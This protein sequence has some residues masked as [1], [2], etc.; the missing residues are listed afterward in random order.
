MCTTLKIFQT[1]ICWDS[2][3]RLLENFVDHALI[4]NEIGTQPWEI[5]I[6]HNFTKTT[7]IQMHLVQILLDW[8]TRPWFEI[9][10]LYWRK[11]MHSLVLIS[12]LSQFLGYPVSVSIRSSIDIQNGL[13]AHPT[14]S[15][16]WSPG[17]GRTR[18]C[19]CSHRAPSASCAAPW[20]PP[21]SANGL[22]P[23]S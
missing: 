18:W 14:V 5:Q 12:H 7:T 3:S 10:T 23:Q 9:S 13:W 15:L 6:N 22:L 2:D 21:P 4:N 11:K 19:S 17:R 16:P 1:K 8:Q 20:W